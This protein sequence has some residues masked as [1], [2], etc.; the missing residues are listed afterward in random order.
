MKIIFI[1]GSLELGAD[2][3]GDYTRRLATELIKQGHEVA[4]L[5]LYDQFITNQ[6]NHVE[7]VENIKLQIYRIPSK[8]ITSRRFNLAK[9]WLNKFNPEWI[10]LQY[11]PFSFN[12]KGLP[13]GLSNHFSQ[14]KH[15]KWHIMFHELWVGMEENATVKLITW[16]IIQKF[17]IKKLLINLKPSVIHT[18]TKLYQ[19]QLAKLGVKAGYLPLFSNIPINNNRKIRQISD[20]KHKIT[21]VNFGTIHPGAPIESFTQEAAKFIRKEGIQINLVLIGRCGVEQKRWV[22]VWKSAGLD[23]SIFGEQPIDRISEVFNTSTYGITTTALPLVEK[24]GSV[25]AM[26]EHN[27]PVIC[28]SKPWHPKGIRDIELPLGVVEYKD[29]NFTTCITKNFN[30]PYVEVSKVAYQ[31]VKDLISFKVFSKKNKMLN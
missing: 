24:S 27:L 19:I 9:E 12:I 10:S 4:A 31:I 3:V 23:V 17:L 22:K 21:F 28:V 2:G 14:F 16:G 18:Q 30:I 26:H 1:C 20:N 6:L 11:V 5:A 15:K 7:I 25:A 13:F 8:W 29:G